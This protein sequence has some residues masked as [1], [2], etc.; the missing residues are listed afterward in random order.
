MMGTQWALPA[1]SEA[2]AAT[3]AVYHGL[4]PPTI[5]YETPTRIVTCSIRPTTR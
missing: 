3:L 2:T 1:R 4:I 5:N